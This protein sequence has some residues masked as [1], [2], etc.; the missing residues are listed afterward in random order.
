MSDSKLA[1]FS[2]TESVAEVDDIWQVGDPIR[3]AGRIE[4]SSFPPW[5]T[6]FFGLILAFLLFQGISTVAFLTLVLAKGVALK[7]LL[8][9]LNSLVDTYA[10]ELIIANT[11]GQV[12]GL[13]IP[14]L[15]LARLHTRETFAFL[16][17]RS[18]DFRLVILS[19]VGLAALIPLVQWFGML[20]DLL[21]W[22]DSIRVW[23]KSQMDLIERVLGRDFGYVFTISM[24]ALTPAICEEVLFRGYIQRQAER[25]W[26]TWK[27][28]VFIGLAFGF[29]HLRPTQA[30]PLALLGTYLAWLT[31]RSGSL[32]PAMI[33]HLVNNAFAS[34][35]GKVMMDGHGEAPDSGI[36]DVPWFIALSAV[37]VLAVVTIIFNR[38]ALSGLATRRSAYVE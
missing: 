15:L 18:V 36:F 12:F 33:V 32:I 28:I 29:Y 25:S 30:L 27:G 2:E 14:A 7:D 5:M 26:G 35:I 37:V 13:L 21:P 38:T 8:M 24:L 19:L 20:S 1:D 31:W 22:P 16:R 34:V 11:V 10:S 23:E 17:L 3:L 6:V 4:R 9:D